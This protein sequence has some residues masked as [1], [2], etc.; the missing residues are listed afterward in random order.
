MRSSDVTVQ[1]GRPALP[2][3]AFI[4]RNLPLMTPSSV[5]RHLLPALPFTTVARYLRVPPSQAADIAVARRLCPP[6]PHSPA[7]AAIHLRLSPLAP[8]LARRFRPPPLRSA[9]IRRSLPPPP[10]AADTCRFFPP[11]PPA[12]FAHH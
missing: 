3:A 5:N 6:F 11:L 8:S 4:R 7:T 10:P 1:R 12:D 9:F 2:P